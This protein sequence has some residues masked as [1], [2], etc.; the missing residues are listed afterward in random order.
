[1][2]VYEAGEDVCA[3]QVGGGGVCVDVE[4]GVFGGADECDFAILDNEGGGLGG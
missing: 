3:V 2:R 4:R 1:M